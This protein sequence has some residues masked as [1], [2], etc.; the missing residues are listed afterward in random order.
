MY[1]IMHLWASNVTQI[2][3]GKFWCMV[4]VDV[5]VWTKTILYIH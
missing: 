5:E 4:G 1:L 2:V 3:L